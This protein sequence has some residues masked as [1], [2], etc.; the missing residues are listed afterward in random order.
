[1]ARRQDWKLQIDSMTSF[2]FKK[3][4]TTFSAPVHLLQE[5]LSELVHYA[6]MSQN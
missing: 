1:M 5:P 4:Q 6:K 2:S 3:A